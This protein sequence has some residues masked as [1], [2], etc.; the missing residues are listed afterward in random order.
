MVPRA[1]RQSRGHL[2]TGN[3]P[4]RLA[5]GCTRCESRKRGLGLETV[6]ENRRHPRRDCQA[7][8]TASRVAG[9]VRL[10]LTYVQTP[11]IRSKAVSADKA[12]RRDSGARRRGMHC[13]HSGAPPSRAATAQ[14]P[15]R[16][17]SRRR[18]EY[19]SDVGDPAGPAD[20]DSRSSADA[21]R[22]YAR[23]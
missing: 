13:I 4:V 20:T 22:E 7:C 2:T 12:L 11:T 3:T 8:G 16:D 23:V 17:R 9:P 19:R 21:E 6:A 5:L 18:W 1:T 14:Y 10:V 15:A